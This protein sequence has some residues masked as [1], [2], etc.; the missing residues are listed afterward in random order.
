MD[1]TPLLICAKQTLDREISRHRALLLYKTSVTHIPNAMRFVWQLEQAASLAHPRALAALGWLKVFP[2]GDALQFDM[3]GARD[4]FVRAVAAGDAVGAVFAW[5]FAEQAPLLYISFEETTVRA[6][7]ALFGLDM[8][9]QLQA[10]SERDPWAAHALALIY[11]IGCAVQAT[12]DAAA[13][14]LWQH[15]ADREFAIAVHALAASKD[16][17]FGTPRDVSSAQRLYRLGSELGYVESHMALAWRLRHS[18]LSPVDDNYS[19]NNDD[20]DATG[21]TPLHPEAATLCRALTDRGHPFGFIALGGMYQFDTS[22]PPQQHAGTAR[23]MALYRRA[24]D[25][26]VIATNLFLACLLAHTGSETDR[27]EAVRLYRT[28][29]ALPA[30]VSGV[31]MAR[32]ALQR[33]CAAPAS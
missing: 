11:R 8:V 28:V 25:L 20:G 23:V 32:D 4:C 1:R 17:G 19:D 3:S 16:S 2:L 14:R 31:A 21:E 9:T 29:A 18:A 6:F 13:V 5:Y 15:W 7:R 12:D 30:H 10:E 24:A 33:L 22:A 26:G 27:A